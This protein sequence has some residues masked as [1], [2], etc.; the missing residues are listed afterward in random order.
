MGGHDVEYYVAKSKE[1]ASRCCGDD[2]TDCKCPKKDTDKFKD[3]I[4]SWCAD[5]ATCDNDDDVDEAESH[6][7][8]RP[9]VL[10][11]AEVEE[12]LVE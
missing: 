4:G 10:T 6:A 5:I 9:Y 2:L 7:P 12:A 1:G 8:K 11:V 3:N